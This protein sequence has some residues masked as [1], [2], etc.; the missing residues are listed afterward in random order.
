MVLAAAVLLI[1][2]TVTFTIL[3]NIYR[4]NNKAWNLSKATYLA[5]EKLDELTEK[6]IFIDTT[7]HSDNPDDLEGCV[8]MWWGETDPYGN[9]AVQVIKVKVVWEDD[10]VNRSVE[11]QSLVAP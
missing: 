10:T 1:G 7:S 3:P 9:D 4:L 6:N 2:V 8:R 11:V 5:Q